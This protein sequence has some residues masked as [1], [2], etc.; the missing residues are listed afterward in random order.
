MANLLGEGNSSLWA[1]LCGYEV[2]VGDQW[3]I[4]GSSAVDFGGVRSE[5]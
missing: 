1:S 5:V 4:S 3:E 2:P